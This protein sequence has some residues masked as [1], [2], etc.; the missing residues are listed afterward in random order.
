M[1][2]R[3]TVCS[4][5][6][7]AGQQKCVFVHV[8]GPGNPTQA[9]IQPCS[10]WDSRSSPPPAPWA[11]SKC[12]RPLGFRL[13]HGRLC[14]GQCCPHAGLPCVFARTMSC[15]MG[16]HLNLHS[17][18]SAEILFR[19]SVTFIGAA[20]GWV[21]TVLPTGVCAPAVA[22]A[23]CPHFKQR[24]TVPFICCFTLNYFSYLYP[25]RLPQC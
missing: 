2:L 23:C 16:P 21:N 12:P 18:T 1:L 20:W 17:T 7:M 3:A 25:T 24:T 14:L 13:H 15:W 22:F 11:W 4:S 8:W 6:W 19:N 9:V 5:M 10:H